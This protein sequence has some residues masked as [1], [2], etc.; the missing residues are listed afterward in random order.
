MKNDNKKWGLPY[1]LPGFIAMALF[2]PTNL[3]AHAGMGDGYL[4]EIVNIKGVCAT[5]VFVQVVM[6]YVL[7]KPLK[8]CK[9]NS[10]LKRIALYC[11]SNT[12]MATFSLYLLSSFLLSPYLC[13]VAAQFSLLAFI[14]L[15][16]F[17][18]LY[19]VI[20]LRKR[21]REWLIDKKRIYY[22]LHFSVLQWFAYCI[23]PF[24]SEA[25]IL[26]PFIYYTDAEY[27]ELDFKLYPKFDGLVSVVDVSILIMLLFSIPFWFLAFKWIYQKCKEGILDS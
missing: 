5:V 11:S 2:L 27:E 8:S 14:P 4:Q 16:L 20:V 19:T 21:A 23:Y 7:W 12:G 15:L 13:F 9:L 3:R 22:M 1:R 24:V 26:N 10:C 25:G 17:F 18:I 6:T